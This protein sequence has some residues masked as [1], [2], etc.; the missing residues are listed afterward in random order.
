[1][2]QFEIIIPVE[3]IPSVNS[4]IKVRKVGNK[5]WTYLSTDIKNLQEEIK[6]AMLNSNAINWAKDLNSDYVLYLDLLYVIKKRFWVRDVTNLNKYVEDAIAM[7]IEFNDAKNL[8]VNAEKVFNDIDDK[9]YIVIVI[10]PK[11]LNSVKY[12]WGQFIETK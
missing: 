11:L 9:E 3:K 7:A 12:K 4:A 10:T 5:A 1:M 8:K 6:Q 2:D